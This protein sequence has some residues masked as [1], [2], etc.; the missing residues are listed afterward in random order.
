MAGTAGQI[1]LGHAGLLAI[2]A[3][4]SALL[5]LDLDMPVGSAVVGGRRDHG[6]ARHVPRSFRRSGCAAIT[7]RSRRWRIGE[8]VGLVILNWESL[9]RGAMGV[10][11]IPP[12]S[13][14]GHDSR[15][16]ALVL[17][18]CASAI[19]VRAGAAAGA[20]A[21]ARISAAPCAPS[22]TTMSRR[23][24]YGISLTA[25]RASPSLSAASRGRQRR[26]HRASLL[27]HQLSDVHLADFASWR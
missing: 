5:A 26:H 22:A 12:L 14:G 9:T 25:T 3:Y 20:A 6:V 21:A 1:S 23:A 2:G 27:L 17:L 19:V 4:A 24:S 16:P 8:I 18:G 13:F 10:S 15:S 11:G 7:S